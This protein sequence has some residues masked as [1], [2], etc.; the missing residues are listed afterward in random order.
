MLSHWLRETM[1][2]GKRGINS[3]AMTIIHPWKGSFDA[4]DQISELLRLSPV[5]YKLSQA[6]TAKVIQ[7][8]PNIIP[9]DPRDEDLSLMV[10]YKQ[11]SNHLASAALPKHYTD[12]K[13]KL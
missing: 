5:P 4:R 3:V 2:S 6:G 11:P 9:V 1:D 10:V 13:H 12:L 7:Y 8:I